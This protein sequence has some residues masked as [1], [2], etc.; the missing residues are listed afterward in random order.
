[1]MDGRQMTDVRNSM[2]NRITSV[3]GL[4][5]SGLMHKFK[6]NEY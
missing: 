4:R 6:R 3:F 1:M 5:T 2:I